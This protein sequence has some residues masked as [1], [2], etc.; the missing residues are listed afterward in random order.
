METSY[1]VLFYGLVFGV[2]FYE[3]LRTSR[4]AQ[5]ASQE[6]IER[7][8]TMEKNLEDSEKLL[9]KNK[10][11]F[12]STLEEIDGKISEI[13][14]SLE[15]YIK[16]EPEVMQVEMDF[17]TTLKEIKKIQAM[18]DLRLTQNLEDLAK[19]NQE[20]SAPRADN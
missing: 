17:N 9:A 12:E 18:L 11:E 4:N 2:T 5:L 10:E 14:V 15:N 6:D 8:E 13:N 20:K 3:I 7:A 19:R 1:E 16:S